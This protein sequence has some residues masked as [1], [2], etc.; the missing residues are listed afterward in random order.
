MEQACG[1]TSQDSEADGKVIHMS[2]TNSAPMIEGAAPMQGSQA[3]ATDGTFLGGILKDDVRAARASSYTTPWWLW[4][5]ILS[6][7]APTVAVVWASLL[8]R[9]SHM[10]LTSRR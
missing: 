9:A 8:A 6:L 3:T 2:M 4:W 1:T 10:R 7:D 5:N